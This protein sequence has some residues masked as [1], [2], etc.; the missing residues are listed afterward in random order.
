MVARPPSDDD[1]IERIVDIDISDEMETSFLEYAYS[2]IYSRALPDAR[3]G[4]KPVQR[5]ILYTM[6]D[7]GIRPDRSHVKSAR[8]VGQVMGLPGARLP[9]NFLGG[10]VLA[11]GAPQ[12][13]VLG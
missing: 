4:L 12:I 8:V 3:D 6:D 11:R 7:M 13:P 2:V 9:P 5:R 10:L 1:V